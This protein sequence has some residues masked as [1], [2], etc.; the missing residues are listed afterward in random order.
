MSKTHIS[1]VTPV[2]GCYECLEQLYQRLNKSL[3]AITEDFEIIMVNDGSPDNSWKIIQQLA[4]QDN[5]VKGINLSRNFGQHY[6]IAAGLDYAWGD[7]VIVMD[8]DLQDQPEEI[9]KLYNKA[10]EGYEQVVGVREN[11]KDNFVTKLTS[12]LFYIVFNYL[13]DQTLDER[14]ANFGIYSKSVIEQVKKYKEKDRS[15]GLLVTLVGFRRAEINIEHSLRVNGASSYDF[16]K[17]FNLAISHILSH[18]NKPLL[19]VVKAGFLCSLFSS[20]Y[21]LSLILRYIFWSQAVEGWT[22][23][24]VS[25]F[26]L[27]GMIISVIGMVGI[28]IGKIYSEVKERPLYIIHETTFLQE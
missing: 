24:I 28:Y 12:R 18:S 6:A 25:L 7:W 23:V 1:V 13:S 17:R 5:R 9:I 20:V 14:I 10:Q 27:S 22:S 16:R 19:L 8:C 11:R 2:Y 15:F 26:F 4:K 21:A 3:S